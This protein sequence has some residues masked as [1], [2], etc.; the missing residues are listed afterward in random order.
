[1]AMFTVPEIKTNRSGTRQKHSLVTYND[2]WFGNTV[3]PLVTIPGSDVNN[4]AQLKKHCNVSQ[5]K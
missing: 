4:M 5:H 1:M 2:M 3:G